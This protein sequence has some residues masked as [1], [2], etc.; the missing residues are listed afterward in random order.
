[1]KIEIIRALIALIGLAR[2]AGINM[3][4]FNAMVELNDGQLS[5]EQI[6]ELAG[7]A[8]ESYRQM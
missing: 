8:H 7:D 4:R 1:M 3:A 6:A 5:D 2:S